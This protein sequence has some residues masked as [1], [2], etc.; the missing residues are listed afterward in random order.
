MLNGMTLSRLPMQLK[1]LFTSYII[2][3]GFGLMM[4]GAQIMIK[5]DLSLKVS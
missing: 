3:V 5:Q 1:V 4:A 2:A